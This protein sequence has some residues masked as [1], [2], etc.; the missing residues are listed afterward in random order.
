M[1]L[2]LASPLVSGRRR[3]ANDRSVIDVF[4]FFA[5]AREKATEQNF[6]RKDCSSSRGVAAQIRGGQ[7]VLRVRQRRRAPRG[8]T[9]RN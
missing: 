3:A 6:T 2:N 8:G 1:R 9:V 5:L 7:S 4:E